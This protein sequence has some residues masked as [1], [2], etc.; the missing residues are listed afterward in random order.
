MQASIVIVGAGQGGAECAIGLRRARYD[1]VIHL[2][3]E[4]TLPPYQ[5]PPLSKEFL[6][7]A[8]PIERLT[9]RSADAYAK[10]GISLHA[11]CRFAAIDRAGNRVHTLDG[12]EFRYDSL[13]LA[14]G[15]SAACEGQ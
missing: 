7:G 9:L 5:R 15:A 11:G 14:T 1:G 4:E 8:M 10:A 13:V 6:A 3:G 12:G 2:L